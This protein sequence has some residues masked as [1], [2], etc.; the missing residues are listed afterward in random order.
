MSRRDKTINAT[1]CAADRTGTSYNIYN[2]GGLTCFDLTVIEMAKVYMSDPD[3]TWGTER[4]DHMAL[5]AI[6]AAD[7]IW[8]H[9][10][11]DARLDRNR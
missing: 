4:L 11:D 7:A 8:D 9:L 3:L 10:E 5:S 6:R 2:R 1:P